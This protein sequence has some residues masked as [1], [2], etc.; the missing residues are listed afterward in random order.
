MALDRATVRALIVDLRDNKKLT[1]EDIRDTLKAQYGYEATKQAIYATYKRA[2]QA[3]IRN[4]AKTDMEY[5]LGVKLMNLAIRGY[6]M[7]EIGDNPEEFGLDSGITVGKL[8]GAL[9]KVEGIRDDVSKTLVTAL[10]LSIL[11][12]EDRDRLYAT[13]TYGDFAPKQEVFTR[14][15]GEAHYQIIQD[16][17]IE[18]LK[19]EYKAHRDK[20]LIK[21]A[22][23]RLG[24]G[25]SLNSVCRDID[26][27][28]DEMSIGGVKPENNGG[29]GTSEYLRLQ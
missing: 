27:E 16:L 9:Q 19:N 24:Y 28:M 29:N 21:Y 10:K 25:V 2:K 12:G 5:S 20:D 14:L 18:Y 6:T 23:G 15:L 17:G 22:L 11:A 1:F 26:D 3:S 7:K 8:R 4:K 13:A